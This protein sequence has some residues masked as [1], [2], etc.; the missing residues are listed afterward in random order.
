ML[1]GHKGRVV[2]SSLRGPETGL[3]DGTAETWRLR[4][5][6]SCKWGWGGR[7][8]NISGQGALYKPGTVLGPC[9]KEMHKIQMLPH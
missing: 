8:E 4:T 2:S 3:S 5:C 1:C 7:T 6:E 9:F